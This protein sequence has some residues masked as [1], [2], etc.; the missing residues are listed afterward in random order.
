MSPSDAAAGY[1]LSGFE[2]ELTQEK[3]CQ[4]VVGTSLARFSGYVGE[5]R[6][7]QR[8]SLLLRKCLL[9]SCFASFSAL[10]PLLSQGLTSFCIIPTF[11]NPTVAFLSPG[12]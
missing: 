5:R 10:F 9:P 11:C 12:T 1:S 3:H 4:H 6:L 2:P 7:S 8:Q